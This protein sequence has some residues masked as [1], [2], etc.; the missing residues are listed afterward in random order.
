[1]DDSPRDIFDTSVL[2]D[3]D[4]VA[5]EHL[6]DEMAIAAVSLAELAAG[7]HATEDLAE[8]A[9]RQDRLQRMEATFHSLSFDAEAARA[10][11]QIYATVVAVGRKPPSLPRC[12]SI[13]RIFRISSGLV[14]CLM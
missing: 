4:S 12:R 9:R 3:L 8:R 6:P 5:A 14:S 1:M 2:I 10:Y 13:R 7:P 11:A